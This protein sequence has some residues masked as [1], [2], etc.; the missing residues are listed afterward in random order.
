METTSH[1]TCK[2]C[3]R[4]L[5]IDQFR[6]QRGR[7]WA[8][9][10]RPCEAEYHREWAQRPESRAILRENWKRNR[11]SERGKAT[12]AAYNRS[13][14]HRQARAMWNETH[15]EQREAWFKE[16]RTTEKRKEVLRRYYANGG[17]A[18][19]KRNQRTAK[20]KETQRRGLVKRRARVKLQREITPELTAAEWQEILDAHGHACRYCGRTD[21]PLTQ[22]HVIPLKRGGSHSKENI[23]PACRP[24]NSRKGARLLQ[25]GDTV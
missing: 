1:K 8:T 9:N 14:K 7:Y 20:G 23:V 24:C 22:D 10:C 13:E 21:L 4:S 5:S 19:V 12:Q 18:Q 3:G 6:L 17:K 11:E 2:R 25:P 16:Y 15:Q